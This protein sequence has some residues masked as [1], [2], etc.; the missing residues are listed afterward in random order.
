MNSAIPALIVA[1][2]V[3]PCFAQ[4]HK[5]STVNAETPDGKLLQ[6]IMMENDPGKKVTL[7][8]QFATEFPKADAYGW[9][10]SEMQKN[11]ATAGNHQKV[12]ETGEKL[13]ALDADD[14]D[15]AYANLKAAE[16]LKDP[17]LVI[18]WSDTTSAVARR[19]ATIPKKE[20]DD[21]DEYKQTVEHAKQVDTYTEYALYATAIQSTDAAKVMAV[22]EKLLQRNP[23]TSYA[24]AMLERYTVVARQANAMDKAVAV[25][26]AAA[27]NGQYSEDML[28]AMTD[29]FMNHK[30]ND[31]VLTYSAKLVEVMQSKPKP[32]GV[33]DE[34]WEKKKST[35]MGL[36]YW[37]AGMT[38]AGQNKYAAADKSLRSALPLVKDNAQILSY[39]LFNLGLA[40][41][42]MAQASK[43]KAQIADAIR[44]TEQA[45][46][47]KGPM[48]AQAVKNVKVMRT[49][50]GMAA[51]SK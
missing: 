5:V 16:A 40:N 42:K 41:Y 35:M 10:L 22:I 38:E 31:K 18:K 50:F 43:N 19:N 25:G 51:P 46:A 15:A 6:S 33:S 49:E 34:N 24:P 11:Y 47:T 17:D 27:A 44:F 30:Q 32:E 21:A 13:L 3:A 45:A 8:E 37:M 4:R 7:S 2:L 1:L 39:A 26:E 28:L 14:L 20:G 12:I 9:V 48:Q 36:G 29:Y 23:T